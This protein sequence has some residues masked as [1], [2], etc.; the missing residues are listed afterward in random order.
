MSP[1]KPGRRDTR[2]GALPGKPSALI[3]TMLS[4]L[5]ACHEDERYTLDLVFSYHRGGIPAQQG[6]QGRKVQ[7]QPCRV[8]ASGALM[9]KKLNAEW[10]ED[11]SP[12]H[13]AEPERTRLRAAD[14]L[15]EHEYEEAL[16][17]LGYANPKTLAVATTTG[18]EQ[19]PAGEQAEYIAG[20][21]LW[22]QERLTGMA[23]RLE[24]CGA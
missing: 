16:R 6:P 10:E 12:S 24:A 3:R 18:G 11:L 13:Y 5:K 9:A 21:P 2:Q 8:C 22:F 1:D 20:E 17:L 15:A 7:E 23:R 4:A 19:A 14:L